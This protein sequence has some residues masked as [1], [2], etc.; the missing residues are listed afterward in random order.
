MRNTLR[1]QVYTNVKD[2]AK[3]APDLLEVSNLSDVCL[4]DPH[5]NY[6]EGEITPYMQ[7]FG[8][9]LINLIRKLERAKKDS[10][11]VLALS[12]FTSAMPVA[13]LSGKLN[14][15][16][17]GEFSA[18]KALDVLTASQRGK[19]A[20][21]K[22]YERALQIHKE[23]NPVDFYQSY[24]EIFNVIGA[25]NNLLTDSTKSFLHGIKMDIKAKRGKEYSSI[26]KPSTPEEYKLM[27]KGE[28][29]VAV[30]LADAIRN[31]HSFAQAEH[32]LDEYIENFSS[33][34]AY[35]LMMPSMF[36]NDRLPK[37]VPDIATNIAIQKVHLK[38]L[39]GIDDI[40][41]ELINHFKEVQ[42]GTS[43]V[44][45]IL[46][47]GVPGC[48]KTSVTY[49]IANALPFLHIIKLSRPDEIQRL[50]HYKNLLKEDRVYLLH[51]D[52][53][54]SLGG[55]GGYELERWTE[56]L[57]EYVSTKNIDILM[58]TN[59][60]HLPEKII[61]RF[62]IIHKFEQPKEENLAKI[63]EFYNKDLAINLKP[64]ELKQLTTG[65]ISGYSPREVKHLFERAKERNEMTLAGIEGLVDAIKRN[66]PA[67]TSGEGISMV[68]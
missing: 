26:L 20:A 58:T 9:R 17:L 54:N 64:E 67:V 36:S 63:I 38:N 53:K 50:I 65:R 47:Y 68:I 28:I 18:V 51:I 22:E 12:D 44:R 2:L 1:K 30:R 43:N 42:K 19:D 8:L 21:K 56:A 13:R 32:L 37:I 29:D 60:E 24:S 5:I 48:G 27:T 14:H 39:I 4:N 16:K 35:M 15:V 62:S 45:N 49:G 23:F 33:M 31:H 52:D 41:T 55:L 6:I 25:F 10:E 11:A 7:H 34:K 3:D 66:R 59:M 61:Q 57:D 46:L 40:I